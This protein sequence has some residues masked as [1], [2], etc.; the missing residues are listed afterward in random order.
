MITILRLD[1]GHS[2]SYDSGDISVIHQAENVAEIYRL[3]QE[4]QRHENDIVAVTRHHLRLHRS[5]SCHIQSQ[6]TACRHHV[7]MPIQV[8]GSFNTKLLIKFPLLIARDAP[9]MAPRT[10]TYLDESIRSEVGASAW[11]RDNCPTIRIPRLL[12]FGFSDHREVRIW[13]CPAKLDTM[14]MPPYPS[15]QQSHALAS[16]DNCG[17]G[18]SGFSVEY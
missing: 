18:C 10:T 12:G 1:S 17:A 3:C 13:R 9:C 16:P 4:L 8:T 2:I 15:F 7:C 14:L 11:M 6:W 5:D